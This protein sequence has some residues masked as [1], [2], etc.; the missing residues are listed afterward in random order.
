MKEAA[1]IEMIS[2]APRT[3]CTNNSRLQPAIGSKLRD[4]HCM[5]GLGRERF[6]R[7]T[8]GAERTSPRSEATRGRA[9]KKMMA[10]WALACPFSDKSAFGCGH[11]AGELAPCCCCRSMSDVTAPIG[12]EVAGIR[13]STLDPT[14][15]VSRSG[16]VRIFF[17]PRAIG[18]TGLPGGIEETEMRLLRHQH[19]RTRWTR[20]GDF[21]F[22][23]RP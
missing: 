20:L 14:P 21:A 7:L 15:H 11:Q 4:Q 10:A 2:T 12:D 8:A 23:L 9:S 13:R 19:Q 3:F 17:S 5:I 16:N 6:Y 1:Q 22:R 18:R